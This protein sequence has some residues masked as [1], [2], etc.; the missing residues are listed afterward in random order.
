MQYETEKSYYTYLF[1]V[2]NP[3]NCRGSNTGAS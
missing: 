2:E 3:I 1:L